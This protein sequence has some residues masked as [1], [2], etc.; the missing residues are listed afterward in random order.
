MQDG[1]GRIV[2]RNLSKSF[3]HVAAVQNLSFQVEPG[4]VTGFL[5]PNGAGKTTALR[6]MLGLVRPSAGEA[7]IDGEPFERLTNPGRVVGAVL[8]A[9]GFHPRRSAINHLRV[10]AA[11]MGVADQRAHEVLQLVGLGGAARRGSGVFSLGMKQRLALATALLG[12]PRVLVL[13]EP[14]NGLDPE[15]IA[16]LRT[17]LKAYA[18]TGRTVLISSHLLAEIEQTIDQVV[19]I[20]RGQ[21]MY[22]GSLEDLRS[23]QQ[24]RVVVRCSDPTALVKALQEAGIFGLEPLPDG[25]LAVAGATV[26]QIGDIATKAQ[27]SLYGVQEQRADLEQLFFRLTSGQWAAPGV[28][29]YAIPGQGYPPQTGYAAPVQ[30]QAGY[31]AQPG[32]ASQGYAVPAQPPPG[33]VVPGQP[34]Q[35]PGYAQPGPATGGWP[36]P[37][38]PYQAPVQPTSPYQQP[39]VPQNSPYQQPSPYQPT[40]PYEQ[41]IAP[42]QAPVAQPYQPPAVPDQPPVAQPPFVPEQPPVALPQSPAAEQPPTSAE[43]APAQ[44]A[45]EIKPLDLPP[46]PPP[47]DAAGQ[48]AAGQDSTGQGDKA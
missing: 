4:S 11:A 43:T 31:G 34:Y 6:M 26:E 44:E 28:P 48:D 21:T 9:Q 40:S 3:G 33:Y 15:G 36:V 19:I 25:Q 30:P 22:Y 1:S 20:S 18:A 17:F 35:A 39:V 16:W 45:P 46:A 14:A 27:V 47:P 2:V 5:G 23:S 41:P 37:Q 7:T 24:S 38:P 32:Y 29:G 42:G 10:Y 13:D 12:D 8:E